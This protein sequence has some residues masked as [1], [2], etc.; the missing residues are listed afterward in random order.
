MLSALRQDVDY[1]LNPIHLHRKPD[2]THLLGSQLLLI[3]RCKKASRL[4]S[5]F[6]TVEVARGYFTVPRAP[7]R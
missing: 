1:F 2:K 4:G 7:S 5:F 3:D 6:G